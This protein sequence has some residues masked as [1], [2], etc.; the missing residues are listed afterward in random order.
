MARK[1]M[2]P[3]DEIVVDL[4]FEQHGKPNQKDAMRDVWASINEK[5]A[6][7]RLG[8]IH[9]I[10]LKNDTNKK[11]G[12]PRVSQ[13]VFKAAV[14]EG[15]ALYDTTRKQ[16]R[17]LY[18]REV[19]S[20]GGEAGVLEHIKNTGGNNK[21]TNSVNDP[22]YKPNT[23]NP[24][25]KS[26]P[27][28]VNDALNT[29][30]PISLGNK[31]IDSLVRRVQQGKAAN[32]GWRAEV[33]PAS[34]TQIGA[35]QFTKASSSH[36]SPHSDTTRLRQLDESGVPI[37]NKFKGPRNTNFTSGG[38]MAFESGHF[39]D[40]MGRIQKPPE[41]GQGPT[42]ADS[43]V[44]SI[45]DVT[46]TSVSAAQKFENKRILEQGISGLKSG[47]L[48]YALADIKK[49][50]T[51]ISKVASQAFAPIIKA[52]SSSPWL[53][54]HAPGSSVGGGGGGGGLAGGTGT[55]T[56]GGGGGGPGHSVEGGS[57]GGG[58]GGGN[59]KSQAA[60]RAQADQK[61]KDATHVPE[62]EDHKGGKT[63]PG[64]ISRW[65]RTVGQ[66]A[67]AQLRYAGAL[68]LTGPAVQSISGAASAIFT[69][70]RPSEEGVHHLRGVN[71]DAEGREA[72]RKS[73]LTYVSNRPFSDVKSVLDTDFVL[74]SSAGQAPTSKNMGKFVRAREQTMAYA[75]ISQQH[76]PKA[77]LEVSR[78]A[79]EARENYKPWKN[80]DYFEAFE[81]SASG[82][83][84]IYAKSNVL[85]ADV[86]TASGY[87]AAI[88]ERMGF[89]P[90]ETK[91]FY[92]NFIETGVHPER[93]GVYTR[94]L[95][96][97]PEKP[98]KLAIIR[99]EY[100]ANLAKQGINPKSGEVVPYAAA[101]AASPRWM[102]KRGAWESVG[103]K[104][105]GAGKPENP[106]NLRLQNKRQQILDTLKEGT[107]EQ[108]VD[109][110]TETAAN[111]PWYQKLSAGR[112]S[113][114]STSAGQGTIEQV[115]ARKEAQSKAKLLGGMKSAKAAEDA[116]LGT[117]P[118]ETNIREDMKTEGPAG[119]WSKMT[120]S[121]G[122]WLQTV[123]QD[124][125]MGGAFDKVGE[126][127]RTRVSGWN[128]ANA[129]K[130]GNK[131]YVVEAM[132]EWEVGIKRGEINANTRSSSGNL[133]RTYS[134]MEDTKKRILDSLVEKIPGINN[135]DGR[136]VEEKFEEH[137][138]ELGK[139]YYSNRHLY[140]TVKNS[141][142]P[143]QDEVNAAAGFDTRSNYKIFDDADARGK[144]AP[145]PVVPVEQNAPSLVGGSGNPSFGGLEYTNNGNL[146]PL[147][148][149]LTQG[150]VNALEKTTALSGLNR[151]DI[152]SDSGGPQT[153]N[154]T[155]KDGTT[156]KIIDPKGTSDTNGAA[157]MPDNYF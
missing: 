94:D 151:S 121:V 9:D 13:E 20:F 32:Q 56:V 135:K 86:N 40:K 120:S 1:P 49:T 144:K 122:D 112:M 72:Y 65:G 5:F 125:G 63:P 95:L 147:I 68:S 106:L 42:F 70:D 51:D 76:G 128:I 156:T 104:A 6:I 75:N 91:A 30:H 152:P 84:D 149:A 140:P 98:A 118:L 57:P 12:A 100:L 157:F 29:K 111:V 53:N 27:N 11:R 4:K 3:I 103:K 36:I 25:K 16:R 102:M 37:H 48:S 89:S 123:A 127:A 10:S 101:N 117:G 83:A 110:I 139:G 15:H 41:P 142:L 145:I 132:R 134:V 90:A 109:L 114:V 21:N 28:S 141:I 129:V 2:N 105:L 74:A 71:I 22:D 81:R 79:A 107:I 44:K 116:A 136:T 66:Q 108:K 138:K 52:A 17:A 82:L 78:A 60:N 96:S 85:G 35:S 88:M 33:F 99:E 115:A 45:R 137:Y 14:G 133:T 154:I 58:P 92:A 8:D 46:A 54:F 113:I 61:A 69:G 87:S 155:T 7:D 93:I 34:V 59:K 47:P 126:V 39:R 24:D 18:A 62:H 150:F 23:A 31:S 146:S 131:D 119:S 80:M 97:D 26:K 73:A 67:K 55:T 50:F 43:H 130:R 124:L 19:A 143:T 38:Q 64:R 153:I 77:A 148:E